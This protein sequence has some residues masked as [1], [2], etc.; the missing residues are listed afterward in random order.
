[1]NRNLN[2]KQ[3]MF[4]VFPTLLTLGNAAC[5]FGSITFAAKIGPES[6]EG[7]NL[8][9]AAGL[10][11][12]AMLF[13]ALDGSAAR[14]AKQTSDFGAQLDSLCD[15]ISSGVAPAFLMLQFSHEYHS[16]F[17]WVIA[18]L[19]VLC[20]VLRLARFNVET[21]E[22]DS[23]EFFSG[24]PAPAAAGLI[25]SFPIA[26]RG[27]LSWKETAKEEWFLNFL[28]W[29]MMFMKQGLP[30]I[31][32]AAACLMVSRIRYVHV[33]NAFLRGRHSRKQLIQIVFT[34]AIIV[35]FNELALPLVLCYITFLP[36]VQAFLK[37]FRGGRLSFRGNKPA[38]SETPLP[39]EFASS[40]EI[41]TPGPLEESD[42]EQARDDS[43]P[44]A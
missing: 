6:S 14:W 35:V 25:A 11:F 10:I 32:L 33:F 30:F 27:L 34:L 31:M 43:P 20:A 24:L 42:E 1:M 8:F 15:A 9:I 19:F 39:D 22:E 4:A 37:E 26:M 40:E 44:M 18:V 3:K 28:D 36:P 16:R 17:L 12:L 13:D 7:N 29:L 23:H 21:D 38:E 41:V 2:R 5:G